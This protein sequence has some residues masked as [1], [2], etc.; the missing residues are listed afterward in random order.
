MDTNRQYTGQ[1]LDR[2]TG[3]MFYRARWYDPRLGR[4]IQADTLVP[5]AGNPQALNRYAYTVG[6]PVRYVDPSGHFSEEQL[7]WLG[8]YR[9][10]VKEEIWDLLLTL[11][12]GDELHAIHTE[13]QSGVLGLALRSQQQPGQAYQYGLFV[14]EGTEM[15]IELL[16]WL[17]DDLERTFVMRDTPD[18]NQ[19]VWSATDGPK[20]LWGTPV[21]QGGYIQTELGA[22]QE[23]QMQTLC[24]WWL[25][26]LNDAPGIGLV[27]DLYFDSSVDPGQ[28]A[29][30]INMTFTYYDEVNEVFY[31]RDVWLR[32]SSATGVTSIVSDN[33]WEN[34]QG[35]NTWWIP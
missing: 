30:D 23:R 9:D 10:D 3:L 13:E 6:N 5:G 33:W 2:A 28:R 35:G 7:N 17:G 20:G 11:Q 4:F 24:L 19:V 21:R 15:P 26:K 1:T 8:Y 18:G 27:V 25:D 16:E 22:A 14:F 32:H 34:V 29:E 12:P 31:T